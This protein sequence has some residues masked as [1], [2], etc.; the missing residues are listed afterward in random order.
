MSNKRVNTYGTSKTCMQKTQQN[1]LIQSHMGYSHYSRLWNLTQHQSVLLMYNHLPLNNHSYRLLSLTTL[2]YYLNLPQRLLSLIIFHHCFRHNI[3]RVWPF[4]QQLAERS[5][6]TLPVNT[7]QKE[8]VNERKV[9]RYKKKLTLLIFKDQ[10]IYL[11]TMQPSQ[12]KCTT[13][14]NV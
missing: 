14:S 1:T 3:Y 9:R 10:I 2:Y 4:I 8:S 6:E 5:L 7:S 12:P 11:D 13:A